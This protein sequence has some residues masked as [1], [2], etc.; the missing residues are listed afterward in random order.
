MNILVYTTEWCPGCVIAK[1]ALKE[2]GYDFTEIDIE[3]AGISRTQLKE[4]MGGRME[5][6]SIVIDGKPIG[7]VNELM[8][9]IWKLQVL[10]L[11]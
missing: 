5:V 6:P 11:R 3:V 10:D 7:G 8:R 9:I 1:K 2:W 4:I